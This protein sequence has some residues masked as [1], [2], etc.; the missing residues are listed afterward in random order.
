MLEIRELRGQ[1]GIGGFGQIPGPAFSVMQPADPDG[2]NETIWEKYLAFRQLCVEKYGEGFCTAILPEN[3]IFLPP[4]EES[5]LKKNPLVWMLAG[6]I[7]Y[8]ILFGR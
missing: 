4:R 7:L 5:A 3:P 8:R 2:I 6:A 1:A